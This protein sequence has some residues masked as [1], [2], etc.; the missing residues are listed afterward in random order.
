MNFCVNIFIFKLFK[1]VEPSQPENDLVER[2]VPHV[3]S[4]EMAKG[5]AIFTNDIRPSC[6]EL[7]AVL[8]QS[9]IPYGKIISINFEEALKAPGVVGIVTAKD[10]TSGRPLKNLY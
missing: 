1:K 5:S 3:W 2:P 8:V 7:V 4:Q 6:D 9:T 10:L